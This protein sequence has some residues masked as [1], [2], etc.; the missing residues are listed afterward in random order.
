MKCMFSNYLHQRAC[1]LSAYVCLL[2]GLS[3]STRSIFTKFGE[4]VAHGPVKERLDF[5][6][7]PDHVTLR[8]G[9]R[10]MVRWG[11]Q[12][13]S[14]DRDA[15]IAGYDLAEVCALLSVILVHI[16]INVADVRCAAK[17]SSTTEK[18]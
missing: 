13:T 9:L 4:K 3:K 2:A 14:Q 11:Q 10:V 8:L 12:Y 7:N 5:D 16:S 17:G 1:V 15:S 18:S 6:G